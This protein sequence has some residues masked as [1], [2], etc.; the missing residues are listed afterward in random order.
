MEM[1]VN[2]GQDAKPPLE[3]MVQSTTTQ[4]SVTK[5]QDPGLIHQD[6]VSWNRVLE[7]KSVELVWGLASPRKI[8]SAKPPKQK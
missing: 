1:M 6:Q 8:R 3:F 7:H 5:D 2:D 4:G